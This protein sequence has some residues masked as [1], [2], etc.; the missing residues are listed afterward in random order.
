MTN[1][2]R[3]R[4]YLPLPVLA[5]A[6]LVW[7]LSRPEP[8]PAR[9][10]G[11]VAYSSLPD[12]PQGDI[13]PGRAGVE[14]SALALAHWL[15]AL[16][17][18]PGSEVPCAE[19]NLYVSW[20]APAPAPPHGAYVGTLGPEPTSTTDAVNG[21][22]LCKGSEAD[23]LMGFRARYVDDKWDVVATPDAGDEEELPEVTTP[24]PEAPNTTPVPSVAL[25][26]RT[27]TASIEGLAAYE[28]Q[29]TCDGTSKPG[30]TALRNLLLRDNA[31]SRNLGI[32]R[33][34][35]IG[36][37]SEHKEGRAFDWGVNVGNAKERAEADAFVV[38]LL[39]TDQF[40]NKYALARRMGVMYVIWN[41]QIW[42]AYR[43]DEGWRPYHGASAHTDHV[44][45]SL[46]WAGA[47]AR[48][49]FWS[50]NVVQVLLASA[51]RGVGGTSTGSA[52]KTRR[53]AS[54]ST[55]LAATERAKRDA[56]RRAAWEQ[57]KSDRAAAREAW[58]KE[59][60]EEQAADTAKWEADKAARDAKREADKAAWEAK[61]EADQAARDLARQEAADK[62]AA[63]RAARDAAKQAAAERYA[64]DKAA[65]D[66]AYAER[67]A[68]EQAARDAA[69][70]AAAEKYAADKA[71][72]DAAKQSAVEKAAADKAARDAARQAAAERYAAEKAARDAAKQA[73]AEKAAAERKAR[74]EAR[75]NRS[76]TTTTA[77]R[78]TT[79]TVPA[80]T[81]TA[82]ATTTT[83]GG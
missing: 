33:G 48:T 4:F 68:A 79:T 13:K 81:T 62:Y 14:P 70:Q 61:H 80:P 55:Q 73:A 7:P 45:L 9:S 10:A 78:E 54:V 24:E 67:K 38:K 16:P 2:R 58:Q 83:T 15:H 29:R 36:G 17:S 50:G 28:P 53:V 74:D 57:A 72:R 3:L 75:R 46:S 64:A 5:V 34:C 42:S 66:Q 82:P 21:I 18:A 22:V 35:S 23:T 52:G 59:H 77:P 51:P 40:G 19:E 63:D 43:A 49:S 6:A 47:Q 44:H 65:R 20:T 11:E 31:G 25:D 12:K 8:A 41:R 69:K 26:G 1:R 37:T 60:A 71:A 56:A 76:T 32:V 27:F 30:T 39:A